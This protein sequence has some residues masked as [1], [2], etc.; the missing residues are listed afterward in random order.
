M[1]EKDLESNFF[2]YLPQVITSDPLSDIE[3]GS[4][5][6]CYVG[7][8]L[9]FF[10]IAQFRGKNRGN[11]NLR[12]WQRRLLELCTSVSVGCV[13]LVSRKDDGSIGGFSSCWPITSSKVEGKD[14]KETLKV[15]W[16]F[17]CA[18]GLRYN[19]INFIKL[20]YKG[21]GLCASVNIG[22]E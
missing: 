15:S 14:A 2:I 8:H 11:G 22:E 10:L 20:I 1:A 16:V 7:E 5:N 12:A 9:C 3:Q 19:F 21:K 17:S 4:R 13:D 6:S 18:R